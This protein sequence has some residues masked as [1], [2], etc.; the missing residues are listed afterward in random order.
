MLGWML[1][2]AGDV[3]ERFAPVAAAKRLGVSLKG[4]PK[5]CTP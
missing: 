5:L 1:V 4:R 3:A 2:G